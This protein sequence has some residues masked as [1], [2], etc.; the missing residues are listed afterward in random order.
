MMDVE[1][2]CDGKGKLKARFA[3]ISPRPDMDR[4]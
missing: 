2:D 4:D 3:E 1:E